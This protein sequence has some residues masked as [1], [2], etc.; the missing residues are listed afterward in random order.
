MPP[1]KSK[2][3]DVQEGLKKAQL[4]PNN[5][6]DRIMQKLSMNT[7]LLPEGHPT[8]ATF[9][10]EGE[11]FESKGHQTTQRKPSISEIASA[12]NMDPNE[13]LVILVVD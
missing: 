13:G 2:P 3:M 11:D 8:N 12:I 7:R 5:I 9:Q 4:P 10:E 6:E 1:K